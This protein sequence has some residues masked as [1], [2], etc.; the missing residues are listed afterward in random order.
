MSSGP[1]ND[2]TAGKIVIVSLS[3]PLTSTISHIM[4]KSDEHVAWNTL[5]VSVKIT[6]SNIHTAVSTLEICKLKFISSPIVIPAG[7][8]N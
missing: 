6:G 5:L 4:P 7:N 8:D 3:S 1:L 2:N